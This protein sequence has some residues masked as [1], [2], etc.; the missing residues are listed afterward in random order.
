MVL[1]SK[2]WN[3]K[4][5][6]VYRFNINKIF[7]TTLVFKLMFIVKVHNMASRKYQ[8]ISKRNIN[9]NRHFSVSY[10]VLT[11]PKQFYRKE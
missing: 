5:P 8:F 4:K 3:V 9:Y 11:K 2:V 10:I 6:N 7:Y 1:K